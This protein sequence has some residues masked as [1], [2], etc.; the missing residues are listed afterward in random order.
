MVQ[1]VKV[2]VH[3]IW[4]PE[5]KT[6]NR[7][8]GGRRQLI[9]QSCPLESKHVP[10]HVYTLLPTII[11]NKVFLDYQSD[12]HT[13]ISSRVLKNSNAWP[14][15]NNKINI[16]ETEIPTLAVFK[17]PSGYTR[18]SSSL[19]SSEEINLGFATVYA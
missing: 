5:F 1:G 11:I 2:F 12:V 19:R 9:L 3:Q 16:Y 13:R 10:G 7:S 8:R 14:P 18:V 15:Q 4:Q 17:V 6:Q